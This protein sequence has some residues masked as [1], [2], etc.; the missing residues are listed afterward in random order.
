VS[1]TAEA[2]MRHYI[3]EFTAALDRYYATAGVKMAQRQAMW[4]DA[5]IAVAMTEPNRP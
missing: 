4:R 1:D 2:V 5:A 3:S